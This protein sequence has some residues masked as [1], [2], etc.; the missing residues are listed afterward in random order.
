MKDII[1]ITFWRYAKKEYTFKTFA[2]SF[3]AKVVTIQKF[4]NPIEREKIYLPLSPSE[5]TNDRWGGNSENQSHCVH[6]SPFRGNNPPRMIDPRGF[7]TWD[8]RRG[9]QGWKDSR[10]GADTL[11]DSD[12]WT[13]RWTIRALL[14]RIPPLPFSFLS[15]FLFPSVIFPTNFLSD[16]VTRVI[17]YRS[18]RENSIARRQWRRRLIITRGNGEDGGGEERTRRIP[19]VRSRG[20]WKI[21]LPCVLLDFMLLHVEWKI[22]KVLRSCR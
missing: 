12:K 2:L 13:E 22:R 9:G 8:S 16:P 21:R 17:Y 1:K 3:I 18:P 20:D 10:K 19:V 7:V 6:L 15:F 5:K 11:T 14:F 4:Q